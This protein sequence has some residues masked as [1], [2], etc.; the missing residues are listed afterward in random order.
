MRL[1]KTTDQ[2][3]NYKQNLSSLLLSVDVSL[4]IIQAQ[5]ITK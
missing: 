2:L 5:G 1:L 4:G 3:K